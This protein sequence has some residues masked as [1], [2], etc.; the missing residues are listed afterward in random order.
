MKKKKLNFAIIGCGSVSIDHANAIKKLGH[1]ILFGSTKKKN[2]L[3]WKLFKKKFPSTKFLKIDKIL[4]NKE[5]DRIVSCLPLE[6]QKKYCKKILCSNKPILIE[7]PLHDNFIKLN[8]ILKNPHA[9]LHNKV[10]GY[11]RR[12]YKTVE[13]LKNKIKKSKINSIEVNISENYKFLKNKYKKKI[14][15][16]FLHVGS[17]SHIIDLICHLLGDLKILYKW[18]FKKKGINSIAILLRAK[19]KFPIFLNINSS[20][21]DKIGL[22]IRFSDNSLWK[23][24]P[25]EELNVYKGFKI[26][27]TNK[28]F[29]KRKYVP[30]LQFCYKEKKNLRPGFLMQMKN[31]ANKNFNKLCGPKENLKLIKLFNQI[32]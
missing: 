8:K 18:I 3:N 28:N 31:F 12:S 13:I 25:I 4:D 21:P 5:V 2:S 29:F 32:I 1:K 6:E 19:E 22:K 10:I 16:I 11:N 30:K 26:K 9:Q 20:D 23:L 7:K 14:N 17:S 27:K 15:N 24:S